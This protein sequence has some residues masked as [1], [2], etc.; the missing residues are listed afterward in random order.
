M[1]SLPLRVPLRAEVKFYFGGLI[2]AVARGKWLE[3]LEI[4][5]AFEAKASSLLVLSNGSRGLA[6]FRDICRKLRLYINE[7]RPI[8]DRHRFILEQ[9]E[10]LR[11][12][13]MPAALVAG[14]PYEALRRVYDNIKEDWYDF[15]A[16]PSRA[17][18]ELLLD[19][20]AEL[21]RLEPLMREEPDDQYKQYRAILEAR[22]RCMANMP[23][24]VSIADGV[25]TGLRPETKQTVIETFGRLFSEIE[26][27]LAPY[28]FVYTAPAEERPA[29][30]IRLE[31]E[32]VEEG[33]V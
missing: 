30:F 15:W 33:G 11:D 27:L 26:K 6:E 22:G 25:Q 3:A 14:D 19:D 17:L 13:F 8:E 23:V 2:D 32:S 28:K 31:E 21:E 12:L 7:R 24:L 20:L 18:L 4:L 5:S 16:K 1:A 9:L 10:R 29:P